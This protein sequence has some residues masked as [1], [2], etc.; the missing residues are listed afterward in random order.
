MSTDISSA[1]D[2]GLASPL[3]ETVINNFFI[4]QNKILSPKYLI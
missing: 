4:K 3:D 2:A 1:A